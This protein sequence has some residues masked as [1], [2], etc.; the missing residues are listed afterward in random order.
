PA[1]SQETY[2]PPRNLDENKNQEKDVNPDSS[3]QVKSNND[4]NKGDDSP[5][6]KDKK[7]KKHSWFSRKS[8][9]QVSTDLEDKD[10]DTISSSDDLE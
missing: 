9:A 2:L 3:D 8:K 4:F 1:V 7:K 6:T 5:R 10:Y